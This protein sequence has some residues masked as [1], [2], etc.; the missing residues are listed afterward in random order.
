MVRV[1]SEHRRRA[2]WSR[3]KILSTFPAGEKQML[4][5]A[6]CGGHHHHKPARHNPA[7]VSR[8]GAGRSQVTLTG[9]SAVRYSR[10]DKR[11]A[12]QAS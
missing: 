2:R 10:V 3:G 7:T 8:A 9:S 1:S 4:D 6:E 12:V 5:N 11:R